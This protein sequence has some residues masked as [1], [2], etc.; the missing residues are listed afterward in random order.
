MKHV[1]LSADGPIR[2]YSV[3]DAVAA[4]LLGWAERFYEWMQHAPEAATLRQVFPSGDIGFCFNEE[5]FVHYLSS[6]I[7]PDQPVSLVEELEADE[8]SD[9]PEPYRS[10]PYYYF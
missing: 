4:D 6:V 2:V 8:L 1:L 7:F 10:Y 9:L 5:D 3:P